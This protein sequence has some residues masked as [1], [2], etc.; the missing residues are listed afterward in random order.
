M[1][2]KTDWTIH[3]A[4]ITRM[5]NGGMTSDDIAEVYD[6]HPGTIRNVMGRYDLQP[7]TVSTIIAVTPIAQCI[8]IREDGVKMCPTAYADGAAS[9]S[10]T[11]KPKGKRGAPSDK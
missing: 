4:S 10:F 7:P 5:L 1:S 11:A 6:V 3:L 9:E 8:I 2:R